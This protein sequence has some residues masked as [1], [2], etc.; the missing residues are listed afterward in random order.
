[1]RDHSISVDQDR[2]A[3]SII[4]KY[5]DIATVKVSTNVYKTNLPSG[6]ILTKDDTSTSY[7]Q[8]EKL[9]GKLNIHYTA[10]IGSF[11]YLL[12]TRADLSL[13]VHKL[14]NFSSNPGK[15][16]SEGL[17]HLLIYIRDNKTLALNNYDDMND[18]P[19]S[20]LLRQASINTENQLMAFYESSRKD[21][22]GTIRSTGTNIILYQG[23]PIDHSTNIPR[24]VDQ[25]SAESDYNA[26]CT[27]GITL[28][29]FRMLIH[30]LLDKYPDIVTEESLLMR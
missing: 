29:Y 9:A 22:P 10:C 13:A 7:E 14:A 12:S 15:V 11:I 18:T 20:D 28:A 26:T 27:T 8:V 30:E 23:V 5:F 2:Y 24:P 6:M 25:S 1:M 19:V 16:H 21:C 3:S 4:E 17:V